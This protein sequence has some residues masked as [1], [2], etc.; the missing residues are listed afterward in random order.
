MGTERQKVCDNKDLIGD[1]Y[2]EEEAQ[3][4]RPPVFRMSR[5]PRLLH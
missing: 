4:T 5:R 1:C 2:W 3:K